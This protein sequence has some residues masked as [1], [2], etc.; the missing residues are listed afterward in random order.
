M[1]VFGYL[2][3]STNTQLTGNQKKEILDKGFAVDDWFSEEAVSGT[4]EAFSRP[5]FSKMI[6]QAKKGDIIITVK[7]DR[8]GRTAADTL[9]AVRKIKELGLSIIILQFGTLDM[10]SS[11]GKLLMTMLAAVAEMERD[12]LLERI[13]AGLERTKEQGTKLGPPLKVEPK[14]MRQIFLDRKDNMK[15]KDIA[16]KHGLHTSMVDRN[17]KKW[18]GRMDEYEQEYSARVVQYA[19]KAA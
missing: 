10:T 14:V 12:M 13:Q 16:V 7:I 1:A 6:A 18:D 9:N 5:Q 8:L 4:T 15:M 3:V 17:L 11:A 19:R 2:R